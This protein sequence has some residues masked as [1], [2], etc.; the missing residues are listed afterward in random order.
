MTSR[1]RKIFHKIGEKVMELVAQFDDV[2]M[3]TNEHTKSTQRAQKEV[4]VFVCV[5]VLSSPP[6]WK[7]ARKMYSNGTLC[8]YMRE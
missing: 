7:I 3:A 8:V 1:S 6:R 4:H 5:F 2:A